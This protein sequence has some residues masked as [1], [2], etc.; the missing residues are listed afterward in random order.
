MSRSA[1]F[2]RGDRLARTAV[3][4]TGLLLTVAGGA[5]LSR[6]LGI[7]DATAGAGPRDRS[8]LPLL[9][10]DVSRWFA[11]HGDVFWP[12]AAAVGLLLAYLG[13]RL[14]RAELRARPAKARSV[15]LTDDARTG[16]T[17][18]GAPLVTSAFVE[19][20]ASV[21]GVENAGAAM[22]GDPGRPLLDVHLDVADDADLADVLDG[23]E[24]GPLRSLREAF[25]LEPAATAVELRLVEA[26]G[27]RLG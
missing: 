26:S 24:H 5:G 4:L 7:W 16:V 2:R 10:P 21:P 14:L 17:R 25:D 18:V 1:S 11:D 22:R 8:Q 15:D 13:Y 6:A 20:L 12:S 27:R 3:F 23:V 19:D 9:T